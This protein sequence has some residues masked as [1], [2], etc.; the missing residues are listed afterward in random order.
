MKNLFRLKTKIYTHTNA[1]KFFLMGK[2][3]GSMPL[4]FSRFEIFRASASIAVFF[5]S[6]TRC[7]IAFRT[8]Q[9]G[10]TRDM[11]FVEARRIL[12]GLD[13]GSY[14]QGGLSFA[15]GTFK[16]PA[17]NFVWELW[18]PGMSL[19][20]F[21][22]IKV[23]SIDRS[24]LIIW[25]LVSSLIIASLTFMLISFTRNQTR[26]IQ[27]FGVALIVIMLLSSSTQGWLLDQGIMYAEGLTLL[28]L[29]TSLYFF[30][31]YFQEQKRHYLLFSG[32]GLSIS[33]F[34]R[35]VNLTIIYLLIVCL[36]I[37]LILKSLRAFYK[38]RGSINSRIRLNSIFVLTAAPVF[39]MGI[40]M[41]FR[42]TWIPNSQFQWVTSAA[43][44]WKSYWMRDSDFEG[45]GWEIVAGIDNWACQINKIV[46]DKIHDSPETN[47][48]YQ[49][50]SIQTIV[51]NPLSFIAERSTHFWDYW[52][53]N[54]RWLY[55]PQS[56]IPA[57]ISMLEG[58]LFLLIFVM[59]LF[60]IGKIWRS[61]TELALLQLVI[62]LGNFLPLL[63]YHLEGR[64]FLP[65]KLISGFII[66]QNLQI[67]SQ[68][69]IRVAPNAQDSIARI[70][71]R[72]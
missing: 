38:S 1:R 30:G 47:W 51:Y 70:F 22:F 17:N 60:L 33:V 57:S 46:C 24:P 42:A 36:V 10:V 8:G 68:L 6:W 13:A 69:Q 65:I 35:S 25:A 63:I 32:I 2:K 53:L 67:C 55:P 37:L 19:L 29:F 66:L 15:N 26:R 28:G 50:L 9:Y 11:G 71:R 34:M 44:S 31:K 45:T 5:F 23:F 18:P 21:M 39:L 72:T 52:I 64:Y 40:W 16:D 58:V 62:I 49:G 54:G 12:G 48:D 7:E 3:V 56:P 20:N 27:F 61:K 59:A 43:N 4:R 14:M 41:T